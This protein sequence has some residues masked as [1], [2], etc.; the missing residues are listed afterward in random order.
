MI[1]GSCLC[2]AV[3]FEIEGEVTPIGMCHC[4]KCRKVSGVASNATL[5]VARD[6]LKCGTRS[7]AAR[8]SYAR[9]SGAN[10]STEPAEADAR[11]DV[12]RD[13]ALIDE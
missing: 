10:R 11:N 6:G 7:R 5:M 8:R 3:A 1:R 2:G 13:V 9:A 12:P 4:S